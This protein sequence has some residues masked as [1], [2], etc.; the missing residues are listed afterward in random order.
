MGS[1]YEARG[2]SGYLWDTDVSEN[3]IYPYINGWFDRT[4]DDKPL[5]FGVSNFQTKLWIAVDDW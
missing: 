3:W 1:T 2:I 4:N 5:D